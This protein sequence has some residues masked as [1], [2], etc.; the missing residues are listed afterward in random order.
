VHEFIIF[1]IGGLAAAGIY[2]ITASGL[3]LTYTTTGIFNWA[4]GAIGMICAFA[5]WQL[6]VGWG[7]PVLPSMFVCLFVLA[8]LIGIVIEAGVMRRLEGVSEASKLVVTLSIALM[9]LGVAQWIWSPTTYRALPPLFNN[10]T[11]VL[12]SI[13]IS[14]DDVTI[15]ILALVVAIGLRLFLYRTR[16]GVTMRASVDDRTLTSLNGSS[17]NSNARNAWIIGS[18]LAALAGILI[19]PTLT[20]SAPALTLLIVNAY[21]ASV[22]GRLRSIPMTFVGAIIL[23][24]GIAYSV[25]YLPQNPYVQN[26]E[27]AV[28]A[29]ILFIALLLLPSARLRG[30]RQL[31][32]RE[33][34]FRPS[35]NGTGLFCFGT[36][37]VAI[38][39]ATSVGKADMFSLNKMWGLAIV[40]L[41]IIP[42]V[43]YA[44]RLSLCQMTFAGIGATMVGHLGGKGNPLSLLAAAGVCAVVGVIIAIPALRLSGI[45]FALATAAFAIT[46]D[47]WVFALPSF[48]LFGHPYAPFG[49]GTLAFVPFRI[50]SL[51]LTSERSQFIAGAVAFVILVAVVVALRRS[52]FGQRLLAMKDSPAA[53]AT[54]GMNGRAS[55]VGVFAFSAALAGV[56][57][58]IYGMELGSAS[59][60]VFQF[61]N[62]LSIMLVMVIMGITSYGAAGLNGLYQGSPFFTNFFPSLTQLPLVLV[63]LGGVGV[64]TTP[65]GTVPGSVRPVYLSVLRRRWLLALIVVV[66]VGAWSLRLGGAFGNWPMTIIILVDLILV[67]VPAYV[68]DYRARIA[69]PAFGL[70][71]RRSKEKRNAWLGEAVSDDGPAG[72][73]DPLAAL[74]GAGGTSG[75]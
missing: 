34:A 17:A 8:P 16:M 28:P 62:G 47:N 29:I 46:M 30:H 21:A 58:G 31:R 36:I 57:G 15:L 10:D 52:E 67:P 12:G 54:L 59:S 74:S 51:A 9:F 13:R 68:I 56:G 69:P 3:T 70:P 32:S 63:G 18:M 7:W 35:W 42:I 40:G 45:Y 53:C 48:S 50:G 23:G 43:G 75:T 64:G 2:A 19:A 73:S 44:G 41:S 38:F 39:F 60:V 72:A 66:F 55:L 61:F 49:S 27:N 1:T 11:L 6:S 24:L 4:H 26:F 71:E 22:I 37:V 5:Y 25:A 20:L 14:Y 65:N 33:L